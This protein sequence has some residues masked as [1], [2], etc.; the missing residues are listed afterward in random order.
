VTA[1]DQ[2]AADFRQR[3]NRQFLRVGHDHQAQHRL[4]RHRRPVDDE[5]DN[6]AEMRGPAPAA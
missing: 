2:L 4:N 1:S 5:Q 3:S 6:Q